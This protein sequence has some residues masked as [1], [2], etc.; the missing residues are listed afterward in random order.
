[1][2]NSFKARVACEAIELQASLSSEAKQARRL[3]AS[4]QRSWWL[5]A[6][7]Q[8]RFASQAIKLILHPS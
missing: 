6:I 1:M 5:L 2:A 4:L 8:T 3:M 7:F